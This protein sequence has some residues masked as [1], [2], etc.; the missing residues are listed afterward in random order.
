MSNIELE[1]AGLLA[2]KICHDLIS[3]ISAVN[4]GLELLEEGDDDPQMKVRALE[5]IT[6]SAKAA[7][8]KLQMM[9]F[10]FGVGQTLPEYCTQGDF[11]DVLEPLA[12]T[13][14]ITLVWSFSDEKTFSREESKFVLN[15]LLVMFDALPRGGEIT[16]ICDDDMFSF[17]LKSSKIIFSQEKKDFLTAKQDIP[18][19]PR[20][21][22]IY[23]VRLLAETVKKNKIMIESEGESLNIIAS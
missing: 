19:E 21:V 11:K 14:H 5:L 22:G 20:Y 13:A 17:T 6:Q 12:Q 23:F 2:S 8:V 15:L 16:I 18:K 4:N 9:R 7:S 1:L 10:A 3:P